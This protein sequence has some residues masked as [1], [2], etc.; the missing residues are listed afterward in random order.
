MNQKAR[1]LSEQLTKRETIRENLIK[2]QKK[3]LED[4]DN[5]TTRLQDRL[6]NTLRNSNPQTKATN[7]WCRITNALIRKY[8][9]LT[10]EDPNRALKELTRIEGALLAGGFLTEQELEEAL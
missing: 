4:F 10:E 6:E 3:Q 9:D 5:E 8:K 2:S 7:A 1:K